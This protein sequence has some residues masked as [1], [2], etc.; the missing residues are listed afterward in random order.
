[1]IPRPSQKLGGDSPLCPQRSK[2]MAQQG[3]RKV[4]NQTF[5]YPRNAAQARYRKGKSDIAYIQRV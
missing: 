5:S 4:K 2:G 1:M 3:T